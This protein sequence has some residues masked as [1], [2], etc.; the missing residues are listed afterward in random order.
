[1]T[2]ELA[3]AAIQDLE[4]AGYAVVEL[5]EPSE[6]LNGAARWNDFPFVHLAPAR[7]DPI[8]VGATCEHLYWIN[9]TEARNVAAALLA[10]ANTVEA[11]TE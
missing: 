1:M 8:S 3:A 9:P 5:P 4:H 2:D 6:S 10:A 11:V 7:D